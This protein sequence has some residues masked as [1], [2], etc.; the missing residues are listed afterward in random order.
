M[1]NFQVLVVI[2]LNWIGLNILILNSKIFFI[3]AIRTITLIHSECIESKR[4]FTKHLPDKRLPNHLP[5]YINMKM[6]NNLTGKCDDN[7][8]ES[9]PISEGDASYQ[10]CNKLLHTI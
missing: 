2:I 10:I 4:S 6:I 3:D 5:N 9:Y 7:A 8:G 1:I